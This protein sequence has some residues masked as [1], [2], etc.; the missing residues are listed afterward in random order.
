MKIIRLMVNVT[1][2]PAAGKLGE[3]AHQAALNVTIPDELRYSGV[4]SSVR[5]PE[6][7]T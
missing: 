3:D 5:P 7:S 2:L 1:N 4:R 6:G